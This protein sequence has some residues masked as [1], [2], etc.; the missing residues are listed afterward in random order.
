[1]GKE[2]IMWFIFTMV[3]VL[4]AMASAQDETIIRYAYFI[5]SIVACFAIRMFAK[6]EGGNNAKE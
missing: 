4:F 6:M 2:I 1:M 5:V 3:A